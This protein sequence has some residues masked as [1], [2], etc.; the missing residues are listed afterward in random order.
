M[1]F[2]VS[3]TS[4]QNALSVV[5]KGIS[6][7]ST[8]PILSGIF[9]ETKGEFLVLQATNLDLSIQYQIEAFIEEPGKAVF[10]G[11]LFSDIVKSMNE[12]HVYVE[13]H[14]N[15]ALLL[16]DSSSFTI[17]TLD[18]N[19]FPS[20]PQVEIL[21]KIT[22]PFSTFDNMV[23]KVAR[24][25]SK[26]SSKP[27]FTGINVTLEGNILSMVTT[28]SYRLALTSCPIE[29]DFSEDFQAVISSSF[30]T[31][32]A[33]L[34]KTSEDITLALTDNQIVISYQDTVFIN[35]K[36]EGS[37]P[38]YKRI[39][40]SEYVTRIAIPKQQLITAVHRASLLSNANSPVKFEIDVSSGTLQLSSVQD[41]GSL[42]ET[43]PIQGEGDN[44]EIGFNCSYITD[45]L[46]SIDD[47][48]VFLEVTASA[49]SG[50]FKTEGECSFLYLVMP[51]RV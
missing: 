12:T 13:T 3:Q 51:R 14:D 2:S 31:D 50:V 19:D 32:I 24:S 8:T 30:M 4:L 20:F 45:G 27:V 42:K 40:P 5:L 43:L 9:I 6:T 46:S 34:P 7:K 29:T 47:E 26:D 33:S 18:A 48:R 10:P 37:Y 23:K 38:A 39:I 36:I 49:K 16:C 44:I 1:K 22:I 15:T 25:S 35:R 11:K 41:A 17:R 21:K 28:D